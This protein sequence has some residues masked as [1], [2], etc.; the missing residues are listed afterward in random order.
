MFDQ[1]AAS[2]TDGENSGDYQEYFSYLTDVL[3]RRQLDDNLTT[4]WDVARGIIVVHTIK[5][6]GKYP[7]L[8]LFSTI[9]APWTSK[10]KCWIHWF[11]LTQIRAIWYTYSTNICWSN[12][13]YLP[14]G[15]YY[16][17]IDK[18]VLILP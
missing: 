8:T 9:D 12:S 10:K 1:A 4:T 15:K 13:P 3:E 16:E 18:S 5:T 7:R 17:K 2:V 11:S 6:H 14:S